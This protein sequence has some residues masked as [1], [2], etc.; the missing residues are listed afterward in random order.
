MPNVNARRTAVA[1]AVVSLAAFAAGLGA[2]GVGRA[3]GP[4]SYRL[5][6]PG[7]AADSGRAAPGPPAGLV[8]CTGLDAAHA[9]FGNVRVR[10]ASSFDPDN[11][12]FTGALRNGCDAAVTGV[13]IAGAVRSAA[14]QPLGSFTVESDL[15]SIAPGADLSFT[16]LLPAGLA[17]GAALADVHVSR[18]ALTPPGLFAGGDAVVID[19]SRDDT[20]GGFVVDVEAV[21]RAGAFVGDPSLLVWAD[22]PATGCFS[23]PLRFPLNGGDA[24]YRDQVLRQQIFVPAPCKSA[25]PHAAWEGMP[26]LFSAGPSPLQVVMPS[27]VFDGVRLTVAGYFCNRGNT[28]L[29]IDTLTLVLNDESGP[30]D[31]LD[32]SGP[33]YWP[34]GHCAPFFFGP[35][36]EGGRWLPASVTNI[37]PA[38]ISPT[39]FPLGGA[40][41]PTVFWPSDGAPS[42]VWQVTNS[43]GASLAASAWSTSL[44]AFDAARN[45]VARVLAFP[46]ASLPAGGVGVFEADLAGPRGPVAQDS[47]WAWFAY[48]H[49]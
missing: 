38:S 29:A 37:V 1:I 2:C 9:P 26:L 18:F 3:D 40:S 7:V 44:F 10:R 15:R 24:L 6:L 27:S 35:F 22:D 14:G 31:T 39:S 47:L 13:Q 33:A 19:S 36:P 21:N 34:A 32:L 11:Q 30:A 46:N 45:P 43:T 41:I 12:A 16:V 25:T 28:P 4:S 17:P 5:V 8:D 20:R 42:A 48:A 23:P 49:P